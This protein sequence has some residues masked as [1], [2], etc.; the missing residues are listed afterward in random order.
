MSKTL[1]VSNG[2][3]A[4]DSR[5]RPIWVE[6]REKAAQD[7]ANVLLQELTSDGSWGSELGK[8]EQGAVIDT[9]NAHRSLV[10]TLVTEAMDRLLLFQEQE[11]DIPDLEK[12]A[13]F[14][15]TVERLPQQSLSYAFYLNIKTEGADEPI[16]KP[17]VIEIEHVRD[18]NLSDVVPYT[19]AG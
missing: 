11:E 19:E 5:G 15:V 12:I 6:E 13:S 14:T 17:F 9:V 3:W 18:P 1:R 8:I 16:T 7:T 4:I 10:Q 2:D